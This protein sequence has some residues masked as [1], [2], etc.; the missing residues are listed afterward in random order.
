[1]AGCDFQLCF[2]CL[3]A[4]Q[5]SPN[6]LL[7]YALCRFSWLLHEHSNSSNIST[8]MPT[9]WL[10]L[11]APRICGWKL[12]QIQ[13]HGKGKYASHHHS[14][15]QCT[16]VLQ[17][18]HTIT[19]TALCVGCIRISQTD[20]AHGTCTGQGVSL[21]QRHT[22]GVHNMSYDAVHERCRV[23]ATQPEQLLQLSTDQNWQ[24]CRPRQDPTDPGRIQQ[25]NTCSGTS[26]N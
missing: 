3:F 22:I 15:R 10:V 18:H 19:C 20:V 24:I 9:H 7:F 14:C 12:T 5:V 17:S 21:R 23:K 1:M 8:R 16:N 13:V 25:R 2:H 4:C 26:Q 6:R 11:P